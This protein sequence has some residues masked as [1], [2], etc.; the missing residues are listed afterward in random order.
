MLQPDPG[1]LPFSFVGIAQIVTFVEGLF[2][3]VDNHVFPLGL[4]FDGEHSQLGGVPQGSVLVPQEPWVFGGF[5]HALFHGGGF[6]LQNFGAELARQEYDEEGHAYLVEDVV[7]DG[8]VS[9]VDQVIGVVTLISH[10][11]GSIRLR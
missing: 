8:L 4:F 3:H 7:V 5:V 11:S 9:C 6:L 10:D 2:Y 1:P